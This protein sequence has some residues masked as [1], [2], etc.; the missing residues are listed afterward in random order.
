MSKRIKTAEINGSYFSYFELFN[1]LK[2]L[3]PNDLLAVIRAA[4]NPSAKIQR[5]Y[6][7]GW[8]TGLVP[9]RTIYRPC[10][11][12]PVAK[13]K[14]IKSTGDKCTTRATRQRKQIALPL[15]HLQHRDSMQSQFPTV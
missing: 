9:V 7:A 4:G 10:P 2:T 11:A 15:K 5:T 12:L 14:R 13:N 6:F 1:Q 3:S 8:R